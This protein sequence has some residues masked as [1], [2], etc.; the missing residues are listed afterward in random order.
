MTF[1]CFGVE[2]E[3][4]RGSI[5]YLELDDGRFVSGVVEAETVAVYVVKAAKSY[6]LSAKAAIALNVAGGQSNKISGGHSIAAE[7]PLVVN[8]PTVSLKASGK[9]TLACGACKVIIEGGGVMIE[10]ASEVTIDGSTIKL[11]ENAL[12]T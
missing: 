12:G 7:G 6:G 5:A 9:I 2:L 4:A 8:A 3:D 11:P 1:R 10:G